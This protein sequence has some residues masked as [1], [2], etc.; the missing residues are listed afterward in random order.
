MS[1]TFVF[2]HRVATEEDIPAIVDLMKASIAENMKAFLSAEEIAAAQESMGLDRSLINDGTYFVIETDVD[3]ATV[4]AACGGWGK[5]RTL[6][7]GDQT[8]GR[9]DSLADPAIH[10]ARIRAM[11]T[12]PGWT[13]RGIGSL[14][15]D[16]GEGAARE[17]GFKTIELGSTVPGYP[18]YLARGYEPYHTEEQV[19]SNGQVKT[20]IHMRKTL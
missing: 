20:V 15:L 13:R 11:Y 1:E 3:G 18:L 8:A 14:L 9:D 6:Y 4:M 2:R 19:A 10:A 12:H 5:R 17:A 7:G 16:L